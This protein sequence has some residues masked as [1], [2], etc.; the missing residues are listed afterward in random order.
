MTTKLISLMVKA[1]NMLITGGNLLQ[2]LV[3]LAFRLAWGIEYF[4]DG[5][6]KLKNHADIVDFFTS[7]HIPFPGLNAWFVGGLELVGGVLLVLGFLSR[8]IGLLLFVNMTVAFL[9]VDT[10]RAK[11]FN[12]F[13]NE[14]SFDAFTQADPFFFWLTALVVLAFG[15]GA[16]S[17]DNL[18][19][20]TVF[21]RSAKTSL[22][23]ADSGTDAK[24]S[25]DKSDG[26]TS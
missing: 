5:Q 24:P 12:M 14:E 2:S 8:P 19:A 22:P 11:V 9:S 3:L 18:L 21:K 25:T 4:I 20:K 7:L 26:Q 13:K 23:P 15:S 10:D 1:Y 6:G 16:I 17:L